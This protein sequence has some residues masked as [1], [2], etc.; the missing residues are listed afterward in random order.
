M[1]TIGNTIMI[2]GAGTG[3]GLETAR[4]FAARGNTVIM[5]ARNEERLRREAASL[6]NAHA[7]ACDIADPDR[8]TA[9]VDHVRRH[10]PDINMILLNAGVTNTYTLFGDEDAVAHATEEMTTNYISAVR[11]TQLFEPLLRDRPEPAMIL[12]TSGVALVPDTTNPTYSATKA[13]LHS[14]VLTMR[15]VL[16]KSAS[17][18]KVFEVMAPLVD[19]PFAQHVH[20]DAKVA[21]AE[22][23]AA[24]LDGV[25]RDELEMHVGSVEH[26]YRTYSGHPRRPSPRST[27]R[28]AGESESAGVRTYWQATD[29]GQ[30]CHSTGRRHGC[31]RATA[32]RQRHCTGRRTSS[33]V[34]PVTVRYGPWGMPGGRQA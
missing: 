23:A 15:W 9:L 27:R 28:P 6:P 7:F 18:I 4:L 1:K 8:V 30:D 26:L 22:V 16:A 33:I 25:E 32:D 13:A 24:I 21:P 20:S 11:L 14:L 5:V 10:H 31:S 19:S 12:T 29:L 34:Q 2:T 17:P 3:I